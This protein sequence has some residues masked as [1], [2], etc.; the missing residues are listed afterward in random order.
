MS[1]G[2][3]EASYREIIFHNDHET[4]L[5]FVI[6][7]LHSA[8]QKQLPDALRFAEAVH[9]DGK[10]SCGSYPRDLADQM[11]ETARER[12][13]ASGHPLRI[14]SRAAVAD[15]EIFDGSCKLC[16]DL[17]AENQV[18]LKGNLTL[19]CDECMTEITNNMPDVVSNK[20][21]RLTCDALRAHFAG[22][23]S[24]QLVSTS[25]M[26]PGHMRADVQA[27]VDRLFSASP[28]RFFGIHEE[29]RYET[30]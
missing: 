27:G 25:R 10:A 24:D 18:S 17:G 3:V 13:D 4:P 11:L 14:T 1:D 9:Q 19:V 21:L 5:Q 30:V 26:F 22:I 12:V 16:G 7:L 8:F 23:P 20:Q 28:L 15:K 29:H 2:Q 6:E